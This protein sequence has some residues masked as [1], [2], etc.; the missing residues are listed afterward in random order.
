M[1]Q[2]L[3]FNTRSCQYLF[4]FGQPVRPGVVYLA[5][6]TIDDHLGTHLTGHRRDIDDLPLITLTYLDERIGFGMD[7]SA[8]TGFDAVARIG[9]LSGVTVIP[10]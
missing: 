3:H 4:S 6:A 1:I 8:L 2:L 7:A 9:K 10:E 5:G